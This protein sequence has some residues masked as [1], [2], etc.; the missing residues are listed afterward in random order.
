[1]NKQNYPCR[2]R[3]S[4]QGMTLV[5]SLVLLTTMTLLGITALQTAVLEQRMSGLYQRLHEEF[6]L[7]E[8]A[9]RQGEYWIDRQVIAPE[10]KECISLCEDQPVVWPSDSVIVKESGQ[11]SVSDWLIYGVR[12]PIGN[13]RNVL[14]RWFVQALEFHPD[15]I[16]KGNGQ[17]GGTYYYQVTAFA[18][19]VQ[20]GGDVRLQSVFA[21]RFH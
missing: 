6:Q 14:T 8:S 5:I 19:N 15:S 18:G 7:A 13:H 21:K 9:L 16:T 11:W 10:P 17:L 12:G 3:Y 1:M 20:G 2:G 4:Q